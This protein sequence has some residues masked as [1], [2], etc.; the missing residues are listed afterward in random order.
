MKPTPAVE[1]GHHPA[2]NAEAS[3]VQQR[4]DE[5]RENQKLKYSL[6]KEKGAGLRLS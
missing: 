6:G 5:P 2:H 1:A 4:D 3:V